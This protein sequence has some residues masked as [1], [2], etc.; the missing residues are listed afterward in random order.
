MAETTKGGN[1]ILSDL[2]LP[3]EVRPG[4]TFSAEAV[5]KNGAAYINPFDGDKCGLAPPGYKLEVVFSGPNGRE[6]VKGPD[7]LGTTEIG[8]RSRTYSATFTA[9]KSGLTAVDVLVR[10]P[11]SGKKTSP[12]RETAPVSTTGTENPDSPG[13]DG[14]G[15]GGWFGDGASGDNSSGS[16]PF[17]DLENAANIGAALVVLLVIAWVLD[18]GAEIAG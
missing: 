7:C 16:G 8:S 1:I 3:D 10:L 15:G 14:S 13:S 9:P 17:A 11:G 4:E 6:K 12:L 5:V 2:R 18:S